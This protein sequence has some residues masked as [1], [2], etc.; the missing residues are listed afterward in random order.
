MAS[1]SVSSARPSLAAAAIAAR[2]AS[3]S[4]SERSASRGGVRIS[5]SCASRVLP[6]EAEAL[7]RV[8]RELVGGDVRL[9]E[10]CPRLVG[11]RSSEP[12]GEN[13]RH[14]G[15][16]LV[17]LDGADH[18]FRRVGRRGERRRAVHHQDGVG[19]RVLEN[20]LHG[21]GVALRRCVADDVDGI[22][23]RPGLGEDGIELGEEIGLQLGER[24]SGLHEVV[25]GE[26]AGAAAIG[27]DQE[28]VAGNRLQAGQGLC[29]REQIFEVLD[30]HQPGAAEGCSHRG[31]APGERPGMRRRGLGRGF[32]P[33]GLD[34]HHRLGA[35]G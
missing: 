14:A 33:S 12:I 1:G 35:G 13:R 21:G 29:R 32:A 31:V 34:H 26:N 10:L 11:N 6:K 3:P 23:A 4:M 17:P 9:L 20:G 8:A 27:H 7:D 2:A 19:I 5:A 22:G 16:V 15:I 18:R 28:L 30:P 24:P 25:H